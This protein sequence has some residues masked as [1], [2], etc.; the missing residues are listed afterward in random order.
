[1]SDMRQCN[2]H[3]LYLLHLYHHIIIIISQDHKL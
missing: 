2:I 1:L 3:N